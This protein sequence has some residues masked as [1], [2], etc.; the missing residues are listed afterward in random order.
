[1]T[2]VI[3]VDGTTYAAASAVVGNDVAESLAEAGWALGDALT[4]SAGMAGSDPVGASWGASYDR[5]ATA[6][7]Q[8]ASDVITASFRLAALLEQTGFNYG[9]AESASVP[10]GTVASAPDRSP[11]E[12]RA[13]TL[14]APPAACGAGIAP[15]SGWSL[16]VDV[17]GYVWPNGHQDRLRAGAD[18]WGCF[19]SAALAAAYQVARA[20][21]CLEIEDA[22]ETPDAIASC[23]SVESQLRTLASG[24]S[25]IGRACAD[26]ADQLDEAHSAVRDELVSLVDWTVGIEAGGALLSV[27]TF[28]G[29]EV[30]AQ[31]A[32]ASRI[33]A[34][35]ARIASVLSRLTALARAAA[36]AVGDVV[37][38]IAVI[39]D[40]L[41]PLL[42]SRIV[43]ALADRAAPLRVAESAAA[44]AE[45]RLVRVAGVR[46]RLADLDDPK[47]F[48]PQ[49]LRGLNLSDIREAMPVSW[50]ERDSARGGGRVF[51]DPARRGRYVRLMPGYRP[52]CRADPVA[53]GPYAVVAQNGGTMKIPLAGNP[54]LP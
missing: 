29:S 32:E 33:A 2:A 15:P 51:D 40:E 39:G 26:Y 6:A 7:V 38:R 9:T 10:G 3:R 25:A 46:T 27:V 16:V 43:V 50:I 1:M 37:Y 44:A 42:T 21:A 12:C 36:A 34:A 11:W 45:E 30:A 53:A 49:S 18:A 4:G 41:R 48:D 5:A 47:R 22:P 17:I 8:A 54:V 28:G 31:A 24:A 19:A 35:A 52:G 20:F 14:P 23:R 13:C